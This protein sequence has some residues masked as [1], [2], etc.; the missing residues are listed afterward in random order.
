MIDEISPIHVANTVLAE[1]SRGGL[2]LGQKQLFAA[3][4]EIY[5]A[6]PGLLP[7]G[8]KI[9]TEAQRGSGPA[10]LHAK[11]RTV[12]PGPIRLMIPTAG[13]HAEYAPSLRDAAR[14]VRKSRWFWIERRR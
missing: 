4:D 3:V 2:V 8:E 14:L 5:K 12:A 1:A 9:V 10:S 11:F 6:R 13:G 7:P